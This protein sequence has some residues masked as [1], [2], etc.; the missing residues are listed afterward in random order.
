MLGVLCEFSHSIIRFI[1]TTT[2]RHGHNHD[3]QMKPNS[4]RSLGA[5]TPAR[6]N[7]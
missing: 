4:Q 3:F 2:S 1:A 7:Q 6:N 5:G